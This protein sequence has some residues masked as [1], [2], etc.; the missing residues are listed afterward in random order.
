MPAYLYQDS[1]EW[2]NSRF[3][4][5][6]DILTLGYNVFLLHPLV[7]MTQNPLEFFRLPQYQHADAVFLRNDY[8]GTRYSTQLKGKRTVA[9]PLPQVN[10]TW[11][12]GEVFFVRNSDA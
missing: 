7:T 9:P 12:D 5:V 8:T 10:V 4:F 1:T 6:Y 2:V 11:V 3:I